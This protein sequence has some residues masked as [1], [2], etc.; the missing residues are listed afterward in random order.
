MKEHKMNDR[1][2]AGAPGRP[3]GSGACEAS[4]DP[5]IRST[6]HTSPGQELHIA[7]LLSHGADHGLHLSDLVRLIG[8]PERVVRQ[9]IEA[10]RRAGALIVAD[11][12]R[13]Y[14]IA[15]NPAE[16]QRFVRSMQHRALEILRTVQAIRG[17]AGIG[18]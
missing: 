17:A 8:L 3:D 4:S 9:Q 7:D 14:W 18:K 15:D 5:T 10:E 16:V 12:R 11:N 6:T 13:G 2:S 1:P